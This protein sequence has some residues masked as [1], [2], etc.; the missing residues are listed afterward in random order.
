VSLDSGDTR[1]PTRYR[2]TKWGDSLALMSPPGLEPGAYCLGG[3]RS[4]H[5]SYGD[6]SLKSE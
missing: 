2:K 1:S 6:G 3:S 4:I 5:L